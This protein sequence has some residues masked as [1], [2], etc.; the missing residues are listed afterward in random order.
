MYEHGSQDPKRE[1]RLGEDNGQ[2]SWRDT[3]NQMFVH[4]ALS[5]RELFVLA[6]NYNMK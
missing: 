1:Y 6:L 3:H 4:I 5:G 2:A